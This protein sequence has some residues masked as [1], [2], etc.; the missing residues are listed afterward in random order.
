MLRTTLSRV[1][2]L[3]LV[4]A[5]LLTGCAGP[6]PVSAPATATQPATGPQPA[7]EE[8]TG[9]DAGLITEP[10]PTVAELEAQDA[11]AAPPAVSETPAIPPH[12]DTPPVTPE[13]VQELTEP[14][15]PDFGEQY[16][17]VTETIPA[18]GEL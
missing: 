7:P 2:L 11:A 3:P 9:T 18:D 8:L 13:L 10:A 12:L 4:A 1:L 5:A 14:A 6:A 16:D 17:V 15:F